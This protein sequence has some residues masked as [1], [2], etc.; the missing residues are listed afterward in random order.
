MQCLLWLMCFSV[1]VCKCVLKSELINYTHRI[2]IQRK[3]FPI[4]F[5]LESSHVEFKKS[6]KCP[7]GPKSSPEYKSIPLELHR[8]LGRKSLVS[9]YSRLAPVSLNPFTTIHGK[10]RKFPSPFV[11]ERNHKMTQIFVKYILHLCIFRHLKL[12]IALAIP[13]SNDEK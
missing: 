11:N 3:H 12:E 4:K 2:I 1:N 5:T 6:K 9:V 8:Q 10:T 7:N 13:A